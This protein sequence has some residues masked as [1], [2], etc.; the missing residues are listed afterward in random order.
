MKLLWAEGRLETDVSEIR[1]KVDGFVR[2]GV[3]FRR[4]NIDSLDWETLEKAALWREIG[5]GGG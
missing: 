4:G 3:G 1:G 2:R 5:G